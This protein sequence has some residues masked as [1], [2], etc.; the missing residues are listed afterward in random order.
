M[1]FKWLQPVLV[2]FIGKCMVSTININYG[3]KKPSPGYQKC[4]TSQE[5]IFGG[6][7]EVSESFCIQIIIWVY[8]IVNHTNT[9]MILPMCEGSCM[10]YTPKWYQ[11]QKYHQTPI[12][13]MYQNM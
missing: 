9:R 3:I 10:G 13:Y 2:W 8:T 4:N 6:Y 7:A 1:G 5:L 12:P 11:K